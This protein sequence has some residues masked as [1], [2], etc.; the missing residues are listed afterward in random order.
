MVMGRMIHLMFMSGWACKTQSAGVTRVFL[1]EW[2][3]QARPL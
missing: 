1:K 2:G 3:L